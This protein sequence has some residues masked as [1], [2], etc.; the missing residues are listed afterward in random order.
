MFI[1]DKHLEKIL[2]TLNLFAVIQK[3][4]IKYFFF[5]QPHTLNFVSSVYFFIISSLLV[6]PLFAPDINNVV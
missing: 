2:T 1:T 5:E 3:S 4:L 6:L